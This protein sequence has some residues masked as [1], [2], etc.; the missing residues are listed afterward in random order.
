[1]GP[2][3]CR[4]PSPMQYLLSVVIWG[5]YQV[6]SAEV[7]HASVGCHLEQYRWPPFCVR[8][9]LTYLIT[10]PT[11][12]EVIPNRTVN[13]REVTPQGESKGTSYAETPQSDAR[14]TT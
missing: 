5:R 11:L 10:Q 12:E 7:G 14:Q 9:R 1:V 8:P 13:L 6:N 3:I 2:E 4:G